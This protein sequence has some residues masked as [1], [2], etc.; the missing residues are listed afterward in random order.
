[1]KR[2]TKSLLALLLCFTLTFGLSLNVAVTD[3]YAD[4]EQTT[5][6]VLDEPAADKSSLEES[7]ADEAVVDQ[8]TVEESSSADDSMT[9]DELPAISTE[10][11]DEIRAKLSILQKNDGIFDNELLVVAKDDKAF[12]KAIEESPDDTLLDMVDLD[13][14]TITMIETT[15]D[16]AT[17]MAEL[18]ADPNV[19]YV[20][21]NFKY[22]LQ[23]NISTL[24]N[25]NDSYTFDQWYL[26][27]DVSV[28]NAWDYA[29][30]NKKVKVAVLDSGVQAD[31]P[32]LKA[33]INAG[34]YDFVKDTDK[35]SDSNG[36]GTHVAGIISAVANNNIGIAGVSY[37]A[38]LL[39]YRVTY[40]DSEG[41]E[42]TD[43]L[44][45]LEAYDCALLDGA[46]VINISL[47]GYQTDDI[48][49]EYLLW[50][51]DEAAK[52]GIVTVCAAGN[53]NTSAKIYPGDYDS[54][55][56]VVATDSDNNRASFSDH[57]QYKDIAAPGVN[58][59]STLPGSQYG[60]EDGTSMASPIVA[61][62]VSLMFAAESS[63]TLTV[64]QVKSILY[65]T[66]TDLGDSG[67]DDYY[68]NGLINAKAALEKVKYVSAS[69]SVNY[70]THVQTYGWQTERKDGVTSGTTGL[71]KRL[72]GIKISLSNKNGA[73]SIEY[74]THVQ[75]YGWQDWVYDGALSGT[76]GESK[77]LEAIRI[78][79]TQEMCQKYDVYYR[80]HAQ[81]IGWMDWAKNGEPA[82]TAGYSYRLEAI[83][84]QLV[85]KGGAAPGNTTTS[86]KAKTLVSYQTHIQSIGWQAL[87]YDGAIA[88]TTGLSKRLE[89]IKINLVSSEYDG[90]IQYN[91]HVQTTGWETSWTDGGGMSGTTGQGKRLEAIQIQL[92][93]EMA[94][95][96]DIYYRVHVQHF[97]WMDWAKNRACAGTTGYSYRL[98]GIQ[99]QLV[100]KGGAAPGKT[101]TPFRSK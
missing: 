60:Y 87:K 56:S 32:D 28:S 35:M 59:L 40:P 20:Q 100:A 91:A 69:T 95:K 62:V 55:I 82:G 16:L 46:Q 24:D 10:D 43:S 18:Q 17:K 47:G 93:G 30:T 78:R 63:L 89:G 97:G 77:R 22:T 86:Y 3:A 75:S 26:N 38:D 57:N 76:T 2:K 4:T 90:K 19:E 21:P 64:D 71:S 61:G 25:T 70:Q 45:L 9:L 51:I 65:T 34:S 101:T 37:N 54:C 39:C 11:V 74:K 15:K 79:L 44:T 31:H 66:A 33:N 58:I 8:S 7:I 49:D 84:I 29:K 14:E 85:K 94:E 23:D 50:Y 52:N 12:Q 80:V 36:H 72:E 83:Q 42:G 53:N 6:S 81:Q 48:M 41:N 67:R 98:E 1:M 73:G 13:D 88:G 96:Y 99:I 5:E 27:G 92:T 68:G